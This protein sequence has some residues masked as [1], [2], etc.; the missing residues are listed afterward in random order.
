MT[1]ALLALLLL[2]ALN[3]DADPRTLVRWA[4]SRCE[5][6]VSGSCGREPHG[7][8]DASVGRCVCSPGRFGPRCEQMH[9][10]ACRLHPDG[11]MACDTFVG[12]MSCACRLSC[13]QRY[14]SMARFNTP[15]CWDESVSD[16]ELSRRLESTDRMR[17]N[18]HLEEDE[19]TRA[20]ARTTPPPLS[21]KQRL[22]VHTQRHFSWD[23]S[24]CGSTYLEPSP[25]T[26]RRWVRNQNGSIWLL[27]D[28]Q[29]LC[30]R[31]EA[32]AVRH[33]ADPHVILEPPC[34]VRHVVWHERV[35]AVAQERSAKRVL[36]ALAGR[37]LV[38]L[39][40]ELRPFVPIVQGRHA[41]VRVAALLCVR[42]IHGALRRGQPSRLGV[43]EAQISPTGS[44][45]NRHAVGTGQRC[46]NQPPSLSCV[47]SST[48]KGAADEARTV[49]LHQATSDVR[50]AANEVYQRQQRG[51]LV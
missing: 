50:K 32:N 44:A 33:V 37:H 39:T 1:A 43:D 29:P 31:A 24:H 41:S 27:H 35:A 8:C 17:T 20:G 18:E 36:R 30:P 6:A 4:S 40:H 28:L 46:R 9:Y 48:R 16:E 12:L 5:P 10:P 14:G 15:L 21:S 26:D 49:L 38:E 19:R 11:E 3:D 2:P 45:A 25:V 23:I 42:A 34:E 22:I 51:W 47:T 7:Y 13:E